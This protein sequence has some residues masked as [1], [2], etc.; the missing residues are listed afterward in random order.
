MSA[1]VG[2]EKELGEL[3]DIYRSDRR[4]CLVTGESRTGT[5]SLV[6]RFC[7]GKECIRVQLPEGSPSEIVD[8]IPEA[9]RACTGESAPEAGTLGQ[10][11]DQLAT[12]LD[13]VRVIAIDGIGNPKAEWF[14]PELARFAEK[15]AAKG[16]MLIL[17]GWPAHAAERT[18]KLAVNDIRIITVGPLGREDAASLHPKMEPLDS[19]MTYLTVGGVPVYSA[20]MNK[21]SYEASVEKCF[22]GQYPRLCMEAENLVRRSSVPYDYCSAILSDI[23]HGEGRPVDIAED[24]GISRQLC[25]IYIKKMESEHLVSRVTPMGSAPKKPVYMVTSSLLAFYHGVIRNNPNLIY[26]D[27]PDFRNI[28]AE[29]GMFLELRFRT[30]CAKY[31]KHKMGCTKTGGWWIVGE[32]TANITLVGTDGETNYICDCKFRNGKVDSGALDMLI[33]RSERMRGLKNKKMTLFSISGFDSELVK[34]AK[35]EGV[36]LIGPKELLV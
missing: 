24:E 17:C 30:F 11:F 5:S 8:S 29:T 1:F 26:A 28:S 32:D 3:G 7:T 36:I 15:A 14:A 25:D 31:L 10:A 33:E 6:R 13:G 18:A 2:R 23:A 9:I 16:D 21:G 12:Y 34:R 4:I 35:K 27:N 22:L 20:L 19:C